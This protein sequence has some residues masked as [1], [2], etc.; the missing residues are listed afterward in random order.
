MGPGPIG[1]V[2]RRLCA[3]ACL[4]VAG[5]VVPREI[6]VRVPEF[7]APSV[8]QPPLMACAKARSRDHSNGS[9]PGPVT[10]LIRAHHLIIERYKVDPI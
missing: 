2:A 4:G 5:V 3:Y 7:G 9:V 6:S 8:C 1:R 10:T